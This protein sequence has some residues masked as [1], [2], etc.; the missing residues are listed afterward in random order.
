MIR[1]KN[2]RAAVLFLTVLAAA[3]LLSGCSFLPGSTKTLVTIDEK[4]MLSEDIVEDVKDSSF[5]AEELQDYI[6]KDI[7]TY[8]RG[9]E[10]PP[11]ELTE[12]R[13]ENGSVHIHME[14]ASCQDYAAFNQ[15]VCFVGTLQEAEDAGYEVDRIWYGSNGREGDP[16]VIRERFREWKVF[17]VSEPIAVKVPDKI[18]YASGNVDITGRMTAAVMTVLND[19]PAESSSEEE[20]T[21]EETSAEEEPAGIHPLATVAEQFAYVIY[22]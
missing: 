7:D 18:L 22:K 3:L 10:E 1:K 8:C 11:V 12:C 21:D 9:K 15:V 17:I 16:E 13:V 14:Y 4:G 2:S 5:T 20:S 6:L 19:E